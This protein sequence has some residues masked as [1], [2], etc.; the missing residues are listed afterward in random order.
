MRILKQFITT[1]YSDGSLSIREIEKSDFKELLDECSIK[2][3]QAI[4]VILQM[5][6]LKNEDSNIDYSKAYNKAINLV[7]DNL[8]VER[9]TVHDKL[10]RKMGCS[11][12]DMK[13]LMEDLFTGANQDIKGIMLASIQGTQK[14]A[15]DKT[16][17]SELFDRLF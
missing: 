7:A 5:N 1:V 14:E 8:N 4:L 15:Q 9:S 17:I 11:A 3:K 2:I 12:K 13:T 16:A 6:A 10:E